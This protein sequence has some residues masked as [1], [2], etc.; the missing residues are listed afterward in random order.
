MEAAESRQRH[1]RCTKL[2][3]DTRIGAHRC[4]R[5]FFRRAKAYKTKKLCWPHILPPHCTVGKMK[6]GQSKCQPAPHSVH[7]LHRSTASD[8]ANSAQDVVGASVVLNLSREYIQAMCG[9]VQCTEN[10]QIS[11]NSPYA[12][13]IPS[14]YYYTREIP[15]T[16]IHSAALTR[17]RRQKPQ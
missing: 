9:E 7:Q 6:T 16:Y 17:Q 5:R 3:H 1:T 10:M 4:S 12:R 11:K 13:L 14:L 2:Q 15:C 8:A